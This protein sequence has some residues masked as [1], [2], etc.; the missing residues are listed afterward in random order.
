MCASH[1]LCVLAMTCVYDPRTNWSEAGSAQPRW[2]AR[3]LVEAVLGS[4]NTLVQS[5]Y[6]CNPKR[7]C[8]SCSDATAHAARLLRPP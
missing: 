3:C 6:S 2:P 1:D 7:I 5:L 4:E 8:L